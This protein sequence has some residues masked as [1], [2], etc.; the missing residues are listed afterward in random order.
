MFTHN[1]SQYYYSNDQTL[2]GRENQPILVLIVKTQKLDIVYFWKFDT[3]F[4]S[5]SIKLVL[6][7]P[8]SNQ[9]GPK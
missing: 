2:R 6:W 8:I 1:N 5:K 7:R 3:K 4:G 9:Q